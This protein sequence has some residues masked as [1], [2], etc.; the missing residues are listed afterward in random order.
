MKTK[1]S[2]LTKY[3]S[4][5]DLSKSKGFT[6]IE[7]LIVIAIIGIL[8]SIILVSLLSARDKARISSIKASVA[9]M[10]S[11]G[12]ICRDSTSPANILNGSGGSAICSDAAVKGNY[13]KIDACGQN[14][15]N[16]GYTV[17]NQNNDNWVIT[18]STC[19]SFSNCANNASCSSSRC[20]FL[21]TGCK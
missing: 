18:L 4:F 16:S 15:A 13:P 19:S 6:L 8:A 9:S 10:K 2:Q 1:K 17:T 11:V 7:L 20:A 5:K 12:L 3:S 21:S 14:D